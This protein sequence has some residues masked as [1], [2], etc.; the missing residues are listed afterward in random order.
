M[1]SIWRSVTRIYM[2]ILG[3]SSHDI[4]LH[5]K[6]K[7]CAW[8][9]GKWHSDKQNSFVLFKHLNLTRRAT[10]QN[11]F[12]GHPWT[13]TYKTFKENALYSS[14]TNILAYFFNWTLFDLCFNLTNFR[15]NVL[16]QASG[17]CQFPPPPPS[18]RTL[19]WPVQKI[20]SRSGHHNSISIELW[21]NIMI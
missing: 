3:F 2:L 10:S 13:P 20:L 11:L 7:Q 1:R 18:K 9:L 17:Y 12:Y 21:Y 16:G 8:F 15:T 19:T 14:K 4:I 6:A 5:N